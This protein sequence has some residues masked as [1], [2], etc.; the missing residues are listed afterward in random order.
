M[1]PQVVS[2]LTANCGPRSARSELRIA[3]TE[4]LRPKRLFACNTETFVAMRPLATMR[5]LPRPAALSA[6]LTMSGM[7]SRAYIFRCHR[8]EP[9]TCPG[10]LSSVPISGEEPVVKYPVNDR[11]ALMRPPEGPLAGLIRP[12]SD[13]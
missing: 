8:S 13:W 3:V 5:S 12:F 2:A 9:E 10:P 1:P 11:W 7:A 6:L 4:P